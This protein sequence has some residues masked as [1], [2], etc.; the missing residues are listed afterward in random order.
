MKTAR[1]FWFYFKRYRI[2]FVVIAAAIILATYLQV[3]APVFLG[4][5]LTE[6]GEK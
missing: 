2:S 6:L 4:E 5:S 3:K 1:F